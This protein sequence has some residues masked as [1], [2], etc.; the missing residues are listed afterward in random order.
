MKSLV[1]IKMAY[2]DMIHESYKDRHPALTYRAQGRDSILDDIIAKHFVTL[3]NTIGGIELAV[4]RE[5]QS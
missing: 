3:S 1:L 4:L 2:Q 5:R